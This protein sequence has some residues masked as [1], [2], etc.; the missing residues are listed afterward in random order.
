MSIT[1]RK[2]LV[3]KSPQEQLKTSFIPNNQFLAGTKYQS[4]TE[5]TLDTLEYVIRGNHRQKKKQF[6]IQMNTWKKKVTA[7]LDANFQARA[8]FSFMQ[9][10]VN[11]IS[12]NHTSDIIEPF[13]ENAVNACYF[14]CNSKSHTKALFIFYLILL[15]T[16]T[17][18]ACEQ[19]KL[20]Q[21]YLRTQKYLKQ[22]QVKLT[23]NQSKQHF[24]Y[25]H[26]GSLVT[27]TIATAGCY[28]WSL[29]HLTSAASTQAVKLYA[30]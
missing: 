18:S 16:P 20:H 12:S 30:F 29:Y 26:I 3:H 17:Q 21:V 27:S 7:E 6:A 11:V 19:N 25:F 13:I 1:V 10:W 9:H 2:V 24:K 4:L 5:V 22:K 28:L 23:A 15:H 14:L 8:L